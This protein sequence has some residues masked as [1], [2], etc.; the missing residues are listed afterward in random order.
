[1]SWQQGSALGP[2]RFVIVM[3]A[4]SREFGVA[5]LWK[6]LCTDGLV[7]VAGTEDDL[8]EGLG[9]WRDEVESGGMG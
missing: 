7:V 5:L 1:V 3:E 8:V 6:L 2:L 4:L 9:K